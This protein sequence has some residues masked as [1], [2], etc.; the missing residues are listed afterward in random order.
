MAYEDKTP[1]IQGLMRAMA[2]N[3]E[4]FSKAQGPTCACCGGSADEFRDAAAEEEYRISKMCQRCQ[5]QVFG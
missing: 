2:N 3:P 4:A 1:A 5:D